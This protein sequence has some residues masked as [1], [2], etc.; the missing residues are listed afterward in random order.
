[1]FATT[2]SGDP[3]SFLH[4]INLNVCTVVASIKAPIGSDM[5]YTLAAAAKAVGLNK[6]TILRAIKSGKISGVK[7]ENGEWH[8][9]PAELH[10]VYRPVAGSATRSDAPQRYAPADEE[11]S[12][13]AFLAEQ[14]L[15]DLKALLDEV[16]AERDA[17][18]DQAQRLA[19]TDQRE[20]RP[21]W[22]RIA[23]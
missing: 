20:R 1:V 4:F 5:S 2:S 9:E 10:R 7:D 18:R 8:I 11:L 6:T 17:W 22:K 15:S 23:G 12:A 14:R 3:R 13:R 16:R 19:L 21:W